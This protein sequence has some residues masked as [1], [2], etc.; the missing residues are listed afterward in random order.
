MLLSRGVTLGEVT[1]SRGVALR[2]TVG[3]VTSAEVLYS[4]QR[5]V[6]STLD[7]LSRTVTLSRGV[8]SV[9]LQHS[10][11]VLFFTLKPQVV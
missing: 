7:S 6:L 8:F 11:E 3:G 5:L 9:E 10:V 4:Q 1:L 2:R